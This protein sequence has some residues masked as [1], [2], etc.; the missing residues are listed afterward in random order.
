MALQKQKT[1]AES[2]FPQEILQN[3]FQAT[4]YQN[5]VKPTHD[6]AARHFPVMFLSDMHLGAHSCQAEA[7]LSFLKAHSA[8][9]IYL[10][11]DIFDNW[12]PMGS[13]WKPAH[14]AVVNLLLDRLKNGVRLVYTPGNHDAFF[15][16]YFGEYFGNL[17]VADSVVHKAADGTRYL[18][19]H[20]DSVDMFEMRAPVLSKVG[21]HCE[22]VLRGFQNLVNRGLGLFEKEDWY[23]I[24]HLM[25]L[26]NETLR[27][28]DSFQERLTDLAK[29][30][31]TDGIICGHYHKPALIAGDG[32]TYVNCGDWVEH[33][34]AVVET[35]GGRLLML[36][37]ADS[38]EPLT[39]KDRFAD[40][41][42]EPTA[43]Q[44]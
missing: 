2:A 27:S 22:S 10:V 15:R 8:D 38:V 5:D 25:S 42:N 34:T 17:I 4:T 3:A 21:A 31:G 28:T 14:H 43:V 1:T 9:T 30:H 24:D 35:E 20:G 41:Q 39:S 29:S 7:L 6:P 16:K 36:D 23:G 12:R 33:C 18:V 11:G 44:V 19:I 26:I 13:N 37:W 32:V 40:P